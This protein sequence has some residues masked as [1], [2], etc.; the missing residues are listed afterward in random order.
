M[1]SPDPGRIAY[2]TMVRDEPV[3]L[4]LWV[5][6]YA[7]A[8]PR[9]HLFIL[10]DG[11][12]QPV[13]DV[14]QGCQVLRLPQ[15][16]IGPGWDDARWRM[17]SGF[18]NTLLERFDVVVLNDVDEL[19]GLDPD[20]GSDLAEAIAEAVDIGVISPFAIEI[21]H[22]TDLEPDPINLARPILS[23][24]RHGRINASYCKPCIIA[25]P[26][27]WSL[28]GHYSD[29]P[30]LHLSRKLF[31]FHLRTM[32]AGLLA[33]RQA[34]RQGHVTGTDGRISGEVAGQGWSKSA[35]EM[36]AYLT[37]FQDKPPEI[38][39]FRFDWQ[40]QRIEASWARDA[41]TGLWRHDRLHNRRSYRIPDR[42]ATLL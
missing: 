13:P 33:D 3:F 23:Q 37:S 22:R 40:R 11:L 36:D 41:A 10:F 17:L 27:R 26:V 31:L 12:D 14:A 42:F 19:I 6:H 18:A 34:R 8:A 9:A 2:V 16:Q 15:G 39:D 25:R 20:A 21:V 30:T 35:A 5:A 38:T 7:A 29:F 4:P 24:R 32:D 1:T 28:G